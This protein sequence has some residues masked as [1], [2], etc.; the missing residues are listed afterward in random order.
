[1]QNRGSCTA[2]NGSK[3]KYFKSIHYNSN[4]HD[5]IAHIWEAFTFQIMKYMSGS[6]FL[7]L[8]NAENN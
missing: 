1:M 5:A 2:H 7:D 4:G 6:D 3:I 8:M